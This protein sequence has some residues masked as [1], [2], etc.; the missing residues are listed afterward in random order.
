MTDTTQ[1]ADTPKEAQP[2]PAVD[3]NE[4]K[5]VAGGFSWFPI[6]PVLHTRD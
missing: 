1:P 5:D 3:E 2:A 4:L 6:P